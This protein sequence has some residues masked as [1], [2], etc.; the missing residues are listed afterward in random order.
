MKDAIKEGKFDRDETATI[1][2]IKDRQVRRYLNEIAQQD[3]EANPDGTQILRALCVSNLI[4][5]AA[6][7]KLSA[8][9]EVA[10]VLAGEPKKVEMKAEVKEIKLEWQIEPDV[11]DQVQ[12]SS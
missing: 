6:L 12:T 4:K 2:G 9:S 5:K 1:L 11:T 7:G 10:I 3:A 8:T